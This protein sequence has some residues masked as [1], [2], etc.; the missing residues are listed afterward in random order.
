MRI[1]SPNIHRSD[2]YEAQAVVYNKIGPNRF[3][4]VWRI[5]DAVSRKTA[6]Y[7][8][9]ITREY[10]HPAPH[11]RGVTVRTFKRQKDAKAWAWRIA[12]Y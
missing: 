9:R 4:E 1:A 12:T 3:V 8:G 7:E 11:Y 5:F 2:R 10:Q 6:F